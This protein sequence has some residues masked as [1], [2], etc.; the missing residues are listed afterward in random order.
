MKIR[1]LE[2]EVFCTERRTDGRTGILEFRSLFSP[3]FANALTKNN[4][5]DACQVCPSVTYCKQ[6]LRNL[7][8]KIFIKFSGSYVLNKR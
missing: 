7:T 8:L 4:T 5:S 1:P 3:N 6:I 2:A